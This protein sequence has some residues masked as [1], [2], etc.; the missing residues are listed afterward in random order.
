MRETQEKYKGQEKLKIK[1]M[2][3][4]A[5]CIKGYLK[6]KHNFQLVCDPFSPNLDQNK[7]QD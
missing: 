7:I 2:A 5:L 6:L 1:L 3:K 4:A